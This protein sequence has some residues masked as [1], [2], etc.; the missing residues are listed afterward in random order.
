MSLSASRPQSISAAIPWTR[1]VI[2]RPRQGG[3]VLLLVSDAVPVESIVRDRRVI[4][5]G[6]RERLGCGNAA[7]RQH[8][9]NGEALNLCARRKSQQHDSRY[10]KV[11]IGVS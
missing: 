7:N 2:P 10:R 1:E 11:A 8:A 3:R 4:E 9:R 6:G 5:P